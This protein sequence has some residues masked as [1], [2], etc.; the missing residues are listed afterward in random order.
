MARIVTFEV[1]LD[2]FTREDVG[3]I[4]HDLGGL[5]Y[6]I[7]LSASNYDRNVADKL[8]RGKT[9]AAWERT[10]GEDL[11]KRSAFLREFGTWFF[12]QAKKSGGW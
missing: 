4:C 5:A 9:P 8:A 10:I 11:R 7:G 3:G 2:R 12:E 1:D 6:K